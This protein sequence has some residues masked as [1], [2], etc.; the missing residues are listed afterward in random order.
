MC[1]AGTEAAGIGEIIVPPKP[2]EPTVGHVG[3]SS[4]D[5]LAIG[6][7]VVVLQEL[8]LEHQ[9]RFLGWP[10][11]VGAAKWRYD[12]AELQGVDMRARTLQMMIAEDQRLEKLL[13]SFREDRW[14]IRVE[15][16]IPFPRVRSA[17]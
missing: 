3:L 2:Q 15:H 8:E 5:D 17:H 7:I 16:R 13:V 1:Q 12:V 11:D 4:G 9:H 10:A 6:E 14:Q